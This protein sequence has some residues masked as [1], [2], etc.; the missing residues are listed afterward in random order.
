MKTVVAV[1]TGQ[2]LAD[3]VKNLFTQLMPEYRLINIIDDGLIHDVIREGTVS[4]AITRRLIGYYRQAADMGA[5]LILNTCSSVGEVADYARPMFD[6]PIIKIDESMASEAVSRFGRI[7]VIATL[8]ST[9]TPTVRLLQSQ[10]ER[11]GRAVQ[12]V[13]GLADGAYHALING[14]PEDHDRLIL[15]TAERLAPDC[16]ALVLAQG[17]MARMERALADRIGKPVLSSPH[18]GLLAVK[19]ELERNAA[20]Q[21]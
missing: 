16:D 12:V 3:P 7:G 13:D 9:L 1:Y 17:S 20:V 11:Q 4:K 18:L 5:D 6:I 19:A 10:A 14:R 2:G 21:P 15:E 8:P